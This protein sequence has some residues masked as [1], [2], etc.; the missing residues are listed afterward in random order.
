M[1]PQFSEFSYGFAVTDEL[2]HI[3]PGVSASPVF[4]SLYQEGQEGYGYD[5]MLEFDAVPLFVQFKLS[6][7]MVRS[8]ARESRDG[9][10]DVPFY[11]MHIRP[12]R[13]SDQHRLLIDIEQ[14]GRMVYYAAP[15]FDKSDDL[16]ELYLTERVVEHSVWIE[17]GAIG[18]LPDEYD[19][20]VSFRSTDEAFFCSKPTR[21]MRRI[22][23]GAFFERLKK[24]APRRERSKNAVSK[25]IQ[26]IRDLLG[27]LESTDLVRPHATVSLESDATFYRR[28][29]MMHPLQK[30]AVESRRR[31]DSQLYLVHRSD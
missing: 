5:V 2:T 9:L 20:C 8:T 17:P 23:S 24:S 18:P 27:R 14:S 25:N 13:H 12:S 4:P 1:K 28:Y 15:V 10:L 31:L 30:L 19:H 16:S 6:D 3:F 21:L 26:W 11:R 22:D 7:V 29:E